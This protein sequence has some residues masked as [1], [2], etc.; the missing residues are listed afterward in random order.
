MV[1]AEKQRAVGARIVRVDIEFFVL[2]P[3]NLVEHFDGMRDADR[4]APDR[5]WC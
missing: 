5:C 2:Q 4:I 1:A 3:V